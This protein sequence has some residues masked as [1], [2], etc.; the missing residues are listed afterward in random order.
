VCGRK[1]GRGSIEYNQKQNQ[2]NPSEPAC[3]NQ[4]KPSEEEIREYEDH[5]EMFFQLMGVTFGHDEFTAYFL[6]LV[7]V[8]PSM[9][10]F[11]P[12]PIGRASA[13]ASEGGH[14]DRQTGFYRSLFLYA[15]KFSLIFT[16]RYFL[17]SSRVTNRGGGAGGTDPL[18]QLFFWQFRKLY[19]LSISNL[20]TLTLSWR[21]AD[22]LFFFNLKKKKKRKRNFANLSFESSRISEIRRRVCFSNFRM[23]EKEERK[24]KPAL[25]EQ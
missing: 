10:R 1:R 9:M 22:N 2:K 11:L 24:T 25:N 3:S 19:Y 20:L 16:E 14:Y 15:F 18:D 13:E 8:A 4:Y 5:A 6:K 12:F 21:T 7:D 23:L 17:F